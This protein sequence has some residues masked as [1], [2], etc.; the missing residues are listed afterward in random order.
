MSEQAV[1]AARRR[2]AALLIAWGLIGGVSVLPYALALQA[3]R[4]SKLT[5]PGGPSLVSL[6]FVGAMQTAILVFFAVLLGLAA[7]RRTGLGAPVSWTISCGFGLAK[8][9]PIVRRF[10]GR[11]L[12]VGVATGLVMVLLDLAVFLPN[13]PDLRA[14]NLKALREVAVWKGALAC[15][16]GG[17]T[18]EILLRLL[19]MSGLALVLKRLWRTNAEPLPTALLWTAN[20]LAALLFAAG[21][22]PAAKALMPLTPLLVVRTV[23]LNGLAGLGFG[24][25]YMRRGLEAAMLGHF[26]CDVILHVLAP[27]LALW[28]GLGR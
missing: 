8:I 16:Y 14:V 20:A 4:L 1:R 6:A 3:D 10:A 9:A 28:A 11:S 12:A 22:L 17:I 27:A 5:T 13:M 21:H 2:Q 19:L 18:E 7:A 24:W 25:L 15:L 23:V 26:T